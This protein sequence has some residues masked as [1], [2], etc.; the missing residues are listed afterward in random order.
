MDSSLAEKR[1]TEYDTHSQGQKFAIFLAVWAIYLI[2]FVS[3][4]DD[5]Q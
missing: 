3:P 2:D 5:A 4:S 1:N